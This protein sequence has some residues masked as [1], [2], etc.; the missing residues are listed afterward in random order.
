MTLIFEQGQQNTSSTSDYL[1]VNFAETLGD[2]ATL[3]NK[4]RSEGHRVEI[5][6]VAD[7]LGKQF[8]YAD[9]K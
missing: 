7:K 3:A 4:L 5:Y 8:G 1:C 9:K 2:I 6:P